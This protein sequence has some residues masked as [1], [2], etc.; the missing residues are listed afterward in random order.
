MDA[1]ADRDAHENV[2]VT[3]GDGLRLNVR[4]YGG[5][6]AGRLPLVCL[7]GLSRNGAD[8]DVLARA[9]AGARHVFAP[10]YRGRGLSDRD[11]NW[12][13][14]ALPVELQDLL[15]VTT[16]LGIEKAVFLG[17]SRGGILTMM[18]TAIRPGLIGGAI[19]NDIGPVVDGTGLAR[20]KSYLG[21]LPEPSD[22]DEA[23]ALLKSINSSRFPALSEQDWRRHAGAICRR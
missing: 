23:V 9:L 5:P 7:A 2:T 12:Q 15:A 1:A 17:T 18:L 20:I 8:F 22:W 19:L 3:A 13:N 11:A 21:K 6:V 10:D 16:A 14:Y 4:V